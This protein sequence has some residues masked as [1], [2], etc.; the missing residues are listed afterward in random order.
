MFL[1]ACVLTGLPPFSSGDDDE[2][3]T[4]TTRCDSNG[5]GGKFPVRTVSAATGPCF[6]A[7]VDHFEALG[8]R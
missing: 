7:A 1:G 4:S 2:N 5:H 8:F 3:T 6:H